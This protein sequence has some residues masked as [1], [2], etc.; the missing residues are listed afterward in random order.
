MGQILCFARSKKRL[1]VF[2]SA[3]SSV[4][5]TAIGCRSVAAALRRTRSSS[6]AALVVEYCRGR[7][8]FC[9]FLRSAKCGTNIPV[10]VV[11]T[12][13]VSAFQGAGGLADLYLEEPVTQAELASLVEI[14]TTA[15]PQR[16]TGP[17]PARAAAAGASGTAASGPKH[18]C[19]AR[20]AVADSANPVAALAS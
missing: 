6:L 14:L 3:V 13:V 4:G 1:A 15:I 18:E 19:K 16:A 7:Q 8:K 17:L 11:S 20:P 5:H 10:L 9:N 12:H 2:S